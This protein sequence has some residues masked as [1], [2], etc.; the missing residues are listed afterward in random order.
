MLC[1]YEYVGNMEWKI[2]FMSEIS[3][4]IWKVCWK[5]ASGRDE[6]KKWNGESM[7]EM[8]SGFERGVSENTSVKHVK[9]AT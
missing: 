1:L 9:K 6:R 7:S 8:W 2:N 3:T 4:G 5:S